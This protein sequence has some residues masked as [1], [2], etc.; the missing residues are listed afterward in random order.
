MNRPFEPTRAAALSRIDALDLV[1]YAR[2][3]TALDGHVSLLSPYL[4]HGVVTVADVTSRIRRRAKLSWN[5]K[6]AFELG[7]CEYFQHALQLLGETIWLTQHPAPAP[8]YNGTMPFDVSNAATGIKIIDEAIGALLLILFVAPP[9]QQR[10]F[11]S[12]WHRAMKEEFPA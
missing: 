7:W 5:G 4:T 10:S 12:F 2:T 8:Q 9:T 1:R 6:F 3:R 11:L